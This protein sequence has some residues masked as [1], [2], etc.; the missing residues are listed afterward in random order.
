LRE[1]ST[2]ERQTILNFLVGKLTK[3]LGCNTSLRID[4][5]ANKV[6]L[7]A[8]FRRSNI[9]EMWNALQS[10]AVESEDGTITVASLP[11][12]L[13]AE[14]ID[15]NGNASRSL[16]QPTAD[17]G[18]PQS[19]G[20]K[21]SIFEYDGSLLETA[22]SYQT[23]ELQFFA[24]VLRALTIQSPEHTRSIRSIAARLQMGRHLAS[25]KLRDLRTAGLL[26]A[27]LGHLMTSGE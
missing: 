6:M 26:P 21:S 8:E 18:T 13:L 23:L 17:G 3:N 11:K 14:L 27:G 24:D 7:A 9:R 5:A 20:I 25:R 4:S 10:A 22:S 2:Q 1:R 12:R 19:P 15:T 16:D